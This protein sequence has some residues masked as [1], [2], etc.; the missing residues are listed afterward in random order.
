MP[1]EPRKPGG[2]AVSPYVVLGFGVLL[3]S[4]GAI[5]VRLAAAPPLAVAFYRM[6]FA[7][8]ILAPFAGREARI[9]WPGLD[10]RPRLLLVASGI[11]LALHFA[12]W[13][14]SLS[15]TSVAAS[16]LLVNTSP[17][18]AIVLSRVFL[19]EQ[20]PLVVKIAIPIAMVGA[21]VIALGDRSSSPASLF[22]NLLAVAGA[23]TLAT[24]QVIG[25]GLRVALPLNA[26]MLAVWSTATLTLAG[27]MA[28][29]GTRFGG[30]PQK[31]WLAFAA[32]AV[33]PTLGGHGLTNRALRS[34]PAPTVGL[35]LLGEPVI[36][37]L[38]AMLLFD[39]V[40]SAATLTGGAVVIAALGLVLSRRG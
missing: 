40:P 1:P 3:V 20:P 23:A 24:Y 36:A 27:L 25:R 37:S 9:S 2:A 19:H 34:L 16:V 31:T 28:A 29:F 14:A 22:G 30:Y 4:V 10:A 21:A 17:L 32:L 11:A 39:E 5:L 15:H 7:S 13:I 12:T 35:F 18:F 38:L 8:L 26:Y 6:A 33:V